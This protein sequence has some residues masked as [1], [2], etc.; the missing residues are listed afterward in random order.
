MAGRVVS[1]LLEGF[2]HRLPPDYQ[3][4][5][6]HFFADAGKLLHL[7]QLAQWELDARQT[8]CIYPPYEQ[9]FQ[10]LWLTP[11][12]T[13]KVILLGQDPYHSPGLA[14]GLAFSI[15]D[16][17]APSSRAFPSSLRNISK[18]LVLDGFTPL[19]HG[20]LTHWAEQGVLLLNTTLTVAHGQAH[21]HQSWGWS[22]LTDAIIF[23]LSRQKARVW[24]LWGKV[25]QK[26]T[27]LLE[28][29]HTHLILQASHPSGLGAYQTQTPFLYKGD[30]RACGHF[31]STNV[32][33]IG[34][35]HT[36]I[37]WSSD[38]SL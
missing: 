23:A 21:S 32:W 10:A 8:Q 30:T 26:K 2:L 27:A 18:A 20:N 12:S 37:R 5:L 3:E 7:E 19:T 9:V 35:Q 38:L 1:K 24:L 4:L 33:L 14:Q 34:Q 36:P 22:S 6:L 13:V 28:G 15:P 31:Q 16:Q 29:T 11:V 25:A 17:I